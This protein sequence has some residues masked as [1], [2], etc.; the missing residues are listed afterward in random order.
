MTSA[1]S[2]SKKKKRQVPSISIIIIIIA[3]LAI[4][5]YA[6]SFLFIRDASESDVI[7]TRRNQNE[8]PASGKGTA[9]PLNGN[10]Y[11]TYDGAIMTINGNTFKLEMPGVDKNKVLSGM[12]TWQGNKVEFVYNKT[13]E[14]CGG[15]KGRYEWRMPTKDLLLFKKISDACTSRAE[16]MTAPWDRF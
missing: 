9:S 13:S 8:A 2:A 3:L 10:W 1:R 5:S 11:S 6:L 15:D 12:I 16:R 14:T 4:L 7:T